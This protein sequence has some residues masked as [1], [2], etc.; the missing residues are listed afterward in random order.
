MSHAVTTPSGEI[1]I[2]TINVWSGLTYKGFFKMGEYEHHPDRR[3][4]LLVSEIRN[5]DPDILAIQEANPLPY[6]VERL[7]A[8]LNYQAIYRVVWRNPIRFF[9]Y[10]NKHAGRPNH[11]C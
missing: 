8:D 11:S 2:L 7:A 6:Y 9:W 4:E 10:S 1:R 3:Y 5:L